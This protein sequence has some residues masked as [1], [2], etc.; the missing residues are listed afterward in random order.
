MTAL[1]TAQLRAELVTPRGAYAALDVVASTGSTNADL[2]EA[3]VRGA[4]D[5]TVLIAE[6]QTA[7]IGRL[8]REWVSPAE[9]GIYL[10]VLLRPAGVPSSSVGSLSIA[11]GLAL[12]DVAAALGVRATLK[13]PNDVLSADGTKLAGILSEL[14][15]GPD[16]EPAVVLGIGLNVLPIG[17]VP[18]GPGGLPATSLA[19]CGA[20]GIDRTEIAGALLRALAVREHQ[21]RSAG[22]DLAV[23]SLLNDYREACSTLR[24][25][26][27]VSMPGAATFSGQAVDVDSA[28]QLVVES[29]AGERVTVFAGD[30]VHVRPTNRG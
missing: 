30:V 15:P 23:A 2:R 13:W 24:S 16:A 19:E 21:W 7:G 17:D 9:A 10:S 11:A 6:E 27:E 29:D 3:A 20:T 28:G 14:V 1:D 25:R 22:G 4:P 5:R 26:V 8:S 12:A 18:P